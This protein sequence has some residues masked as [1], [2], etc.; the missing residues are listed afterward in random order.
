MKNVLFAAA[1]AAAVLVAAPAFA[2]DASSDVQWYGSLGYTF[3]DTDIGGAQLG[4]VQGRLGARFHNYFG[5]EG[6]GA[7]GVD[8]DSVAGTSVKLN[9]SEA[10]YAVGFV[11]LTPQFDL[12]G[13][14]GLGSSDFKV[15]GV[16]N[17]DTSV[18][19]GAGAQWS[20]DDSNAVRG[21]Y[22]RVDGDNAT[23]D[24]WSLSYVRK[25]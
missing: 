10:I 5:I 8:N 15:G 16:S 7:I 17:S 20:F 21:D 23:S 2:Q 18:N 19:Y 3:Y 25:F 12:I 4:A 1:A 11:P 24:V 22:T 14:V 6:E 13:R 9:N